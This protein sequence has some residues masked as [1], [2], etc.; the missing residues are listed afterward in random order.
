MRLELP[1][2]GGLR[3]V[4][5]KWF[6]AKSLHGSMRYFGREGKAG[7]A[8]HTVW[9]LQQAGVNTPSALAVLE[10]AS[11]SNRSQGIVIFE[12]IGD[13]NLLAELRQPGVLRDTRHQTMFRELGAF[14]KQF[15]DAGFRHRDLQGGNILVQVGEEY[16]FYLIDTNRMRRHR[17]LTPIQRIRDLERLAF[18]ES[19]LQA[20]VKG[21]QLPH[22][23]GDQTIALLRQRRMLMQKF[24]KL[25]KPLGKVV[26]KLW[27]YAW[28]IRA[29]KR[30][31][32][33]LA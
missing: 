24:G 5:L 22:K 25:P 8:W 10:G 29:Y 32:P 23:T 28:E 17:F 26:Y 3:P 33:L 6:P 12:D 18:R 30:S 11:L 31:I 19:E 27:Y 4:W 13:S 15:H 20:F 2:P 1:E 9:A 7:R 16:R 14:L 21:Y